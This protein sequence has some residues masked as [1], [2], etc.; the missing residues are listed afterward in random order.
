MLGDRTAP[1]PRD[2]DVDPVR[3]LCHDMRQPLAAILVLAE[4]AGGAERQRLDLIAEQARWLTRL[5]DDVLVDAAGDDLGSVDVTACA[6]LVLAAAEPS[7]DCTLTLA[8]SSPV[9][10]NARPVALTR[11]LSCLVDNAVRAAGPGGHVSLTVDLADRVLVTVRD[12]GPGLGRV[13]ARSSLGLTITRALVAA[14][15]GTFE[16]RP[17]PGGGALARVGLAPARTSAVAS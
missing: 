14:C 9:L 3:A 11:A 8:S 2:R 6:R 5:V 15:D 4:S 1:T 13:P 17:A 7:A 10:A 12:D 16:L